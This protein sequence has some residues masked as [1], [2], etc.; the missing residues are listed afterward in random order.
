MIKL[1]LPF[2]LSGPELSKL[3]RAAQRF[4]DRVETWVRWPAQQLD[5]Q[6]CTL[7]MLHLLAWQR[8]VQPFDD[9]PE[10]LY[11]KRVQYAYINARDA[12]SVAGLQR[13]FERLE[14]GYV[15]IEERLPERDWDIIQ[16]RLS[17]QQ[18]ADNPAL[19]QIILRKYG[20][21]C[22]RYEFEVLT[23]LALQQRLLHC[24]HDNGF[25]RAQW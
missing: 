19:L 10:G 5:P 23:P 14:I 16:L 24:G 7:G 17:D 12:G 3:R 8:H 4:W 13:I 18:L 1:T 22:R 15:E 6:T 21:T 20:R 11:R 25:L 9:E 2:W